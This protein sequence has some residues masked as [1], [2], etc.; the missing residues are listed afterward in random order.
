M[1]ISRITALIASMLSF[2]AGAQTLPASSAPSAF[3]DYRMYSEKNPPVNWRAANDFVEK[4]DG[5]MGHVRGKPRMIKPAG[6]AKPALKA[7]SPMLSPAKPPTP[8]PP[9]AAPSADHSKHEMKKP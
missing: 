4:L 8:P 2:S 7:E 3:T 9:N 5:H 1:F 6:D